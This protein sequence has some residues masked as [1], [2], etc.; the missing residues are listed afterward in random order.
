VQRG[1]NRQTVFVSDDDY[2]YYRENLIEFKREFNCR[3]YAYCLMTNHVHLIIDPGDNPEM[4]SQ[5]M[6]R[7]AGRQTRYVN[8][9][10]KRTGSL[11]EGRFKSS[12]VSTSEYLPACCQYIEQNPVRASVVV[13]PADY[14]WSSFNCLANGKS[15]PS[16]DQRPCYKSLG[17]NGP[18]RQEAW[19][20]YVYDTHC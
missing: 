6:K 5:L 20:T 19:K 7:V 14:K 10:E 3:I 17:K 13:N 8:K 1:H 16:V 2:N 9:L 12:I 18:E 11:W 4:L 15:D